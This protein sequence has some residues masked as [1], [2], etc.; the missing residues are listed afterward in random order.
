MTDVLQSAEKIEKAVEDWFNQHLR[1]GVIARTTAAYNQL[2]F[3]KSHLIAKI[4]AELGLAPAVPEA[5][6]VPDVATADPDLQQP[7]KQED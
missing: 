1:T 5:P 4:K 2:L 7:T 3:S 6:T